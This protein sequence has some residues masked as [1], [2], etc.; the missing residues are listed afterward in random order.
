MHPYTDDDNPPWFEGRSAH[1]EERLTGLEWL[2]SLAH[3]GWIRCRL[4]MPHTERMGDVR[5]AVLAARRL[6]T[7]SPQISYTSGNSAGG[8]FIGFLGIAP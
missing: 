6:S 3:P 7:F 2:G 8:G 4:N 5:C 1:G